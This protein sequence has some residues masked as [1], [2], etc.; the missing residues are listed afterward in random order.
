MKLLQPHIQQTVHRLSSHKLSYKYFGPYLVLQ[1]I[2][3]VAYKLQ[4]PASSRIHPVFHVSLLKQALPPSTPVTPDEHLNSLSLDPST[5]SYKVID[6]RLCKIGNVV[7]PHVLLRWDDWPEG[8]TTWENG[9]T[10]S[11]L[12][13]GHQA[14]ATTAAAP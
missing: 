13:T 1:R 2:G 8:W 10:M 11:L 5:T 4:L 3:A 14:T 7:I 6:T 9:N 12:A